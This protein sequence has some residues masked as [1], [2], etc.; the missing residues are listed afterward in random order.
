MIQLTVELL[1]EAALLAK[2]NLTDTSKKRICQIE[3]EPIH[4]SCQTTLN[5]KSLAP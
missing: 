3:F 4:L 2:I 1:D 5:Q